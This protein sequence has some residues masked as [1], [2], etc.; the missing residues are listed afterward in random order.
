MTGQVVRI[1]VQFGGL[2]ILA[3]LLTPHDYGLMAMMLAIMGITEVFRDFGLTQ[4]AVQARTLSRQQRDNLFWANFLIGI[5]LASIVWL[6]APLLGEFFSAPE[7]TMM[8]QWT[9]LVFVAN[10]AATQYRASL[11]REMRFGALAI[12]DI[13]A[14]ALGLASAVVVALL[15]GGYWALVIQQIVFSIVALVSVIGAARWVPR[16][17]S[18]SA[19]MRGLFG[20]GFNLLGV[21]LVSNLTRNADSLILGVRVGSVQLGYYDRAFQ[22]LLLPLNQI[23]APATKVAL[24]VLARL[25]DQPDRFGS[26]LVRGQA[27]LINIVAGVLGFVAA[28]AG[29]LIE[30]VLG[31]QWSPSSLL[32]QILCIGGVAQAASYACY[33]VFL[34]RGLTRENLYYVLATRPILIVL[35]I[36]G[37][38]WGT[39]GVAIAYSVGLLL[40]WPVAIFWLN[41]VTSIPSLSMFRNGAL[42]FLNWG[43]CAAVALG[44][45]QF[46]QELPAVIQ[47][48]FAAIAYAAAVTL[49]F[50]VSRPF[51]EDFR[52]ILDVAKLVRR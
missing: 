7:L 29:P 35:L 21:Q 6:I 10:G 47:I 12:S 5:V 36:M 28:A 51:R 49:V 25:N 33:W 16:W 17:Y 20:Y 23:N 24:P 19:P 45:L 27:I 39:V 42:A 22:I 46:V 3:R 32:L 50:A 44:A 1:A 38:Y 48:A 13:L 14:S 31:N 9:S 26:F 8:A 30:V 2:V 41:R 37:S 11:N 52:A 18:V 15:S 43:V 40:S 34:A 4:A